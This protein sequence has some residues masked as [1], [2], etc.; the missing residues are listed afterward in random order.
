MNTKQK[1]QALAKDI[2]EF[3]NEHD[4]WQDCCIYLQGN[5]Y[6]YWKTWNDEAGE[7]LAD[8]LYKYEDKDPNVYFDYV[9]NL[10]LSMSFEGALYRVVNYYWESN[11]WS[12][13]YKKFN[14]LFAKYDC[15]YEL[16][17][18]WNLTVY[19]E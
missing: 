10:T 17:D 5:A 8:N 4:L 13:L 3:C 11:S 19:L 16:G 7:K 2:Y 15:Y 6:T 14:K 18:A 1:M 9:N 12:S